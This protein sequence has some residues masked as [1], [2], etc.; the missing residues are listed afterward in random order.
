MKQI[1][2][3]LLPIIILT[4]ATTGSA[5]EL[6][7]DWSAFIQND[8]RVSVAEKDAPA[9]VYRNDSAVGLS[10]N[11]QLM[12]YKLRFVGELAFVWT[13]FAEDME[14]A[15]LTSRRGVAP[16]YIESDAAFIEV[17][18]I[19]PYLDLRVG[20]QIVQWGAGDQ[21]NPTNNLNA[22][23]LEDPLSFGKTVANQMIR[24]D[25]NPA[26]SD[27]ILTAVWVPVFQ[28]AQLPASSLLYIGDVSGELPFANPE[29]RLEAERMRNIYLTN[30]DSFDV[31]APRVQAL[32]PEHSLKNS[33]FGIRAQWLV[34]TVDTSISYYVGR[35]SMPTS[36]NSYSTQEP[37]GEFSETGTPIMR[38]MTDVEL[39]YPKKQV[40]GFDFAGELP[41]LDN[42]GFWFEGAVVFPE[43]VR[44]NFDIT[45]IVPSARIINDFV[46]TGT[47]FFKCTAGADYSVN[48]HIFLLGQFIHGM[49]DEFGL[50]A[51]HNYWMTMMDIK[52]LQ[53]RLTIR[54][55][56]MGEV[57]HDDEDLNLDDDNDGRVES[58]AKGATD[59][60]KIG[61]L[62]YY[63]ELIA[64]PLDGLELSVGAYLSFGHKESKFA[65][66]AA[67]PSQVFFR[68]RASF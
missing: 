53:E 32:M 17:L 3:W 31:V 67:G 47:P 35:D 19:L 62:V 4:A 37:S 58:Q 24:L 63:P 36:L 66:D 39:Y 11:A 38:V 2:A 15:S 34:G 9:S 56:V 33:Q 57:P 23:D 54:Q 64:R 40:L 21:F 5:L 8:L 6:E 26:D 59:D 20:R 18:E 65:M 44:M 55:V 46:V 42:M 51:Q 41:F 48:E 30:P 1:F 29:S 68:A 28:P 43:A 61:S 12:P 60:G 14:F 49:P 45:E 16:Y 22:L 50:E 52:L 13:G 10:M 27:F 25:F 7:L